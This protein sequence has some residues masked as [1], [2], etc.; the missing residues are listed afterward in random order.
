VKAAGIVFEVLCKIL[1]H[2][3]TSLIQQ[4]ET[5]GIVPAIWKNEEK[6]VIESLAITPARAKKKEIG[7]GR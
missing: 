3:L 2:N 1:C 5:R 4:R 6:E 7:D